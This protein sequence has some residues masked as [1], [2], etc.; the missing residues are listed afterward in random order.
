VSAL[1]IAATL[2][3]PDRG[4][5]APMLLTV[6][7]YAVVS[8]IVLVVTAGA[9]SFAQLEGEFAVLYGSLAAFAVVLLVVP[10][11]VLGA[12][13]VKLS[14][15]SNDRRL[16]SLRLLGA[17]TPLIASITIIE[18]AATAL[19]GAL[20][21]VALY[22]AAAPLVGLVRFQ[23]EPIGGAMWL[24]PGVVAAVAGAV[25]VLAAASAA[26][27]LRRLVISPLGV[28]TRATTPKPRWIRAAIVV[29]LL[30]VMNLAFANLAV[31]QDAGVIL[32]V[33]LTGFALCLGAL[34]LIGPWV[35]RVLGRVRLRSAETPDRLLAARSILEN[36]AA[37]WREVSGLAMTTFVAVVGGSGA[38]LVD[39]MSRVE[40]DPSN[41][42]FDPTARFFASDIMTG[43]VITLVVS[44]LSVACSTA[45]TQAATTLDRADLYD[46]LDRLGVDQ[47][48]VE[49]ARVRA[50]MTPAI[51]VSVIAAISSG[52]LV[53]PVLGFTMVMAPISIAVVAGT[54]VAGMLLIRGSV[55]MTSTRRAAALARAA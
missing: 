8:A 44:F 38:A 9:L 34:G 48:T 50:V 36:P 35:V 40:L 15:R 21:G 29:G 27:G 11:I 24:H 53:L 12:A 13:A 18:A 51:T 30:V 14:A 10:V 33:L 47:R 2:A 52:V 28:R 42:P 22:A 23:G 32:G 26:A 20:A 43:L 7:A 1:S 5:R 6:G 46:G 49:R 41:G 17:S 25:V 16:S 55:S 3:R 45:I 19:A 4:R 39:A 54:V 31:F 37:A